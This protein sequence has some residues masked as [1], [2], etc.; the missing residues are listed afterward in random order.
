MDGVRT[1]LAA[2]VM[3]AN[4]LA[5]ANAQGPGEP[6]FGP[7]DFPLSVDTLPDKTRDGLKDGHLVIYDY[8]RGNAE[9]EALFAKY[10]QI[11]SVNGQT[12]ETAPDLYHYVSNLPVG[13]VDMV[14][15]RR[16]DGAQVQETLMLDENRRFA[17]CAPVSI[18]AEGVVQGLDHCG[19]FYRFVTP[20]QLMSCSRTGMVTK[21]LRT[22]SGPP[23]G[24]INTRIAI[25]LGHFGCYA[26]HPSALVMGYAEDPRGKNGFA[27][28]VRSDVSLTAMEAAEA[29][30][31]CSNLLGKSV[32][33]LFDAKIA[34][35]PDYSHFY[36]LGELRIADETPDPEWLPRRLKPGVMYVDAETIIFAQSATGREYQPSDN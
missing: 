35:L 7:R 2:M 9:A 29:S 23:C 17:E 21:F 36:Y 27:I 19:D 31:G 4:G 14:L 8:R 18:R 5:G 13:L 26:D 22:R 15:L 3:L 33:P 32:E 10:D 16:A 30:A 11:L 28:H 6:V 20:A 24:L 12:F 1:V 34:I 25:Q